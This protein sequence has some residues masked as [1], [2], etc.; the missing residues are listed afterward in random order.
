MLL[1]ERAPAP[2]FVKVTVWAALVVA[3]VWL[4]NIRPVGDKL[5]AGVVPA[6]IEI[7]NCFVAVC[8]AESVTVMVNVLVP[9]LTGVPDKIPAVLNDIPVLHEPLQGELV[10]VYGAVPLAAVKVAEYAVPTTPA[11]SEVV[12]M[13]SV[14]AVTAVPLSDTCC[15]L[16]A[17]LS[18]NVIAPVS[19]PAAVG[20]KVTEMAQLA[21]AARLVPQVLVWAKL[22]EA[23]IPPIERA[24]V[25][26]FFKVI[27]WAALVV[28]TVWL[29][30]VKLAADKLTAGVDAC[31]ACVAS[32][33]S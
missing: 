12:V 9:A 22:P 15:G 30:K 5:T 23:A 20:V 33:N 31:P 28:A 25:P 14:V 10:Q 16:A 13:A 8:P 18:V 2:V 21:L 1:I 7:G 11:G 27:V 19:V 6:V 17:A 26:E 29:A 4:A 32:G 24:P 3:T